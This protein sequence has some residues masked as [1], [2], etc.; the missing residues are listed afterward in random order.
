NSALAAAWKPKP[1]EQVAQRQIGQLA[2]MT[3]AELGVDAFPVFYVAFRTHGSQPADQFAA[4]QA[5]QRI[6]ELFQK[7]FP[8]ADPQAVK[9]CTEVIQP[10]LAIAD[11]LAAGKSPPAELDQFYA[12]L[13][14]FVSHYQRVTK[15]PFADRQAEIEKLISAAIKLNPKVAKYYTTRG[16][17]RISLTP[18]NVD[19]A[20]ADADAAVKLDANLPAAYA[21]QGHAMIYRSRQEP[22]SE[23]RKADLE[24]ALAQC[25]AAVEKSKAEDKERSMHLLYLSMAQLERAN[26]DSD[27][28]VKKTLLDQAVANAQQAVDL[29][30]AYPDYAYTA[31]GNA[32]ED[33]AWQVGEDPEKNYQAAIDAFSQA[34]NNNPSA[35][36]PLISRARCGYRAIAESKLDPKVLGGTL[37]EDMQSA[38]ADLQQA[39][40]LNPNAVEPNL[41]LGKVQ[42]LLGQFGDADAALADAVKLAEEQK[43]PERAMFLVE[44]TRN[45]A[46]NK[47]LPDA[48]RAKTVRERAEQLKAAPSLG[49]SS[50]AKQA[51]LIIGESLLGEKPPKIADALKEYDAVLVDYDKAD[52]TK[53]IDPAKAD[54]SDVSLLL[55]R[56]AC[57]FALPIA[58]WNLTAA[59][60]MLKDD[61]RAIRLNPA[62]HMGAMAYWYSANAKFKSLS[63]SSPTFTA[64]KKQEYITG[65][66]D[67]IRAAIRA[68]PDDPG[69]WEWRAKGAQL[70]GAVI[71]RTTAATPSDAIKKQAAEARGWIDDA[72]DQVSKRPDLTDKMTNLQR[73]QQDL[74]TTLTSKGLPRT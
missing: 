40:Q 49:G 26:F 39:K 42:Q 53:P 18:P 57:R 36:T 35:P 1:A 65:A 45:A 43:L 54:G 6:V 5:A 46:L 14:E 24:K 72:I 12:A 64:A 37:Q 29:E 17:A 52:A 11:T 21:L 59:E 51:A 20:L 27:P 58:D 38:I 28:K 47:D 70:L 25:K 15:W 74:E 22:S 2:K 69:S 10:A 8:V 67:D 71:S 73:I 7:Q 13:A 32:L 31:L 56:S 60:N 66:I 68:A 55:A 9:L 50:S 63:S 30:K 4:V 34:I 44:W 33:V 48:D 16:V 62:P 61:I 23:A 19:G 3:N 41:W